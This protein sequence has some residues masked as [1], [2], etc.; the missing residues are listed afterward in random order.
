[1]PWQAMA[2]SDQV[3]HCNECKLNVYNLSAMTEVEI[4]RLLAHRA[5]QRICVR[6]YRRADGTMLTQ[7]CPRGL[8]SLAKRVPKLGAA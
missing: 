5:D 8:K 3:R 1:M 4:Q 2:G 6:F 7:N